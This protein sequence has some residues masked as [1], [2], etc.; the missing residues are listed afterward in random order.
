MGAFLSVLVILAVMCL[1][2]VLDR[3]L[4][5]WSAS[6]RSP[7]ARNQAHPPVLMQDLRP[8]PQTRAFRMGLRIGRLIHTLST[9]LRHN[10]S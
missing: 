8:Q 6:Q 10:Q 2:P 3:W 1:G 5:P 9:P 7:K 4:D